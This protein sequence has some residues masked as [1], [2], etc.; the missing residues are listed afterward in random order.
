MN[1]E[2]IADIHSGTY[3][4]LARKWTKGDK[5]NITFPMEEKWVSCS[6]HSRYVSYNLPGGEI[7]YKEES[8]DRIPYAFVRGPIVYSLDTV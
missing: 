2:D 8:T 4:K 5:V 7:M 6:H 3:L 1:G